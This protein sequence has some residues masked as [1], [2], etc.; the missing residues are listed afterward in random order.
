MPQ[1]RVSGLAKL[2]GCPQ[3]WGLGKPMFQSILGKDFTFVCVFMLRVEVVWIHRL[4][5]WSW[6]LRAIWTHW[7]KS[8]WTYWKLLVA[9]FSV[10][11][12]F[13]PPDVCT[14]IYFSRS[15]YYVFLMASDVRFDSL[16]SFYAS[17]NV[18]AKGIVLLIIYWS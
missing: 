10:A 6:C 2:Q 11:Y 3:T 4:P 1:S 7:K 9:V 13:A 12:Q 16:F 18:V 17:T 15:L 5:D 8:G 14:I